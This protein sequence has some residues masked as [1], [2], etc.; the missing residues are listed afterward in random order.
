MIFA[1][2]KLDIGVFVAP[3]TK[4]S[5]QSTLCACCQRAT[6]SHAGSSFASLFVPHTGG[7]FTRFTSSICYL[8]VG[9]GGYLLLVLRR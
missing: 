6:G 8:P 9:F 2:E 1:L 7:G 4:A 5:A 3:K